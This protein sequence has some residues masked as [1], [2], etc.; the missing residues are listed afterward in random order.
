MPR[1]G[2]PPSINLSEATELKDVE[3]RLREP[4]IGWINATLQ[5]ARS[6]NLQQ[7]TIHFFSPLPHI[8]PGP[9]NETTRW[10]WQDLD[11]LLVRLWTTFSIR[12]VFVYT[13]KKEGGTGSGVPVPK[14]LPELASRGF[15]VV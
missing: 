9:I 1:A 14:L 4:N 3:F 8:F 15:D 7:I 6:K 10:E 13:Q 5:T 12:L 2:I 11:H